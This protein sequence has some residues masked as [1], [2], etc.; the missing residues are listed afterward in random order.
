MKSDAAWRRKPEVANYQ[1]Y[2]GTAG[3][4]NFNGLV[5]HYYLRHGK[6]IKRTFR[7][8]FFPKASAGRKAMKSPSACAPNRNRP[9]GTF[10]AS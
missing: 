4:H 9:H 3:P 1:I 8:T 5:R 2:A 7:S 10:G 6:Q